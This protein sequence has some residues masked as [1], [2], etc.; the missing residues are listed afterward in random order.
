MR[1]MRA[2]YASITD[3]G[4]R[5]KLTKPAPDAD[6]VPKKKHGGEGPNYSWAK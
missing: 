6:Q 2:D 4:S 3:A 5:I 1:M